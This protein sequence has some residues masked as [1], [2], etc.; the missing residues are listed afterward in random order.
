MKLIIVESSSKARKLWS[1]VKDTGR[2]VVSSNGSLVDL[3]AKGLGVDVRDSFSPNWRT[4]EKILSRL[5]EKLRASSEIYLAYNPDSYGE[6]LAGHAARVLKQVARAPIYRMLLPQITSEGLA[7]S[8]IRPVSDNLFDAQVTRRVMDRV[9]G[10]KL[11][12]LI[13]RNLGLRKLTIGRSQALVLGAC[14][15]CGTIEA[16]PSGVTFN[17]R[18]VIR[19]AYD[20]LGMNSDETVKQ[21]DQM[22]NN[23]WITYPFTQANGADDK[24]INDALTWLQANNIPPQH[25]RTGAGITGIRPVSF[26][27]SYTELPKQL[28]SLYT[29]IW[30][31]AMGV[32]M[33]FD[34]TPAQR[35]VLGKCASEPDL[36]DCLNISTGAFA[37]SLA[38]LLSSGYVKRRENLIVPTMKGRLIHGYIADHFPELVDPNHYHETEYDL[39]RIAEGKLKRNKFLSKF[40]D[41]FDAQLKAAKGVK[42]SCSTEEHPNLEVVFQDDGEPF[43]RCKET[44]E[45][46]ALDMDD[47]G[48]K[49]FESTPVEGTCSACGKSGLTKQSGKYGIYVRCVLC[50][51]VQGDW[52]WWK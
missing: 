49:V 38:R 51:N 22:Y 8:E 14:V 3:P 15:Q 41:T 29:L 17:E 36:L 12:S 2:D 7:L 1:L 31:R 27:I 4:D 42:I 28:R 35:R 52:E 23:G 26:G 34:P 32:C 18:T 37:H 40:W 13:G 5:G 45:W 39:Q 30:A 48:P 44:D 33:S 9:I 43:L 19:A 11:S 24:L 16:L 20:S 50:N 10:Y 6:Y 21:L 47:D 25:T 46:F